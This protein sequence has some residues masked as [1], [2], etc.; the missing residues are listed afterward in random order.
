VRAAAHL[1]AD[2]Y[3]TRDDLVRLYGAANEQITVAH[4]GVDPDLGPVRDAERLARVRQQYGIAGD[5]VLYVGTLQP[6]KNLV[7]L[8]EAFGTLPGRG[9]SLVLAGKAGWLS[10]EI[11]TRA[12][13]PG[14]AGRV[15]VTG[16]VD[17]ADLD[18]LYSGATLFC[19]PSLYEGFCMPVLEAMA[20]GTPV[21]CSDTSS[22][23]EVVGDAAL[24]FDPQDVSDMARAM[25]CLLADEA[26]RAQC[27]ARGRARAAHFT[28]GACAR[29]VMQVLERVGRHEGQG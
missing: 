16:Y 17:E 8:I 20:C 1:I 9:L 5:Y 25:A 14:L 29:T 23:P 2:S 4:L 12:R 7:R 21:V 28:W 27:V 15:I 10:D 3:A 26:L 6:R 18:A 13:D 19:M 24:T 22:L 11:L